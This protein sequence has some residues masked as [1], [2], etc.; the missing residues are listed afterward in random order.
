MR[1]ATDGTDGVWARLPRCA[2]A[3]PV[4]LNIKGI[5]VSGSSMAHGSRKGRTLWNFMNQEASISM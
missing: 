3:W 5:K 2:C 4:A 1:S